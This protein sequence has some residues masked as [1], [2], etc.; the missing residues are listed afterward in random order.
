MSYATLS[1]VEVQEMLGVQDEV[2]I[3][4]GYSFERDTL[5][6]CFRTGHVVRITEK[7]VSD[8]I[9]EDMDYNF[10]PDFFHDGVKRWYAD[11]VHPKLQE[12]FTTFGN[13]LPTT[14]GGTKGDW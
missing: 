2:I 3:C 4:H 14:P 8:T 10:R 11:S 5:D 12:L 13:R 1:A 6:I 7:R 9:V